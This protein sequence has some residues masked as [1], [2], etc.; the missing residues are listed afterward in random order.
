M[1]QDELGWVSKTREWAIVPFGKK[2]MSI[3]NGQQI[4]VHN[5]MDTAKRFVQKEMKRK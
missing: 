2:F 3:Y 5:S 1:E 4:S